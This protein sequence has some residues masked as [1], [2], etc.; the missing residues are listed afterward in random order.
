ME[1]SREKL[2][3]IRRLMALAAVL[4]L[5]VIYS[6]RLL[7]GI[8]FLYNIVKPFVYG[9]AIAFVL[10]ILMRAFEERLLKGWRGRLARRCKRPM[11]IILSIVTVSLLVSLVVGT[12]A[13]QVTSTAAE[14]GRKIPGFTE[15][16]IAWM[17]DMAEKYPA[18]AEQA[19][20]L[21]KLE[22]NWDSIADK[23]IDFLKNGA[24]DMLTSTVNVAG[25]IISG[26]VNTVIAF[27]FALYILAQKERLSNQGKRI[28]SAFFP[29]KAAGKLL[30]VFALLY[31]NFSSF[32]TGQCL[33]AV[34]L[35]AMFVISMS[36][37]QMPYALMVGVLIAFTALIPIVGAFIGCGVGAFLIL[38]DNPLQ[39]MWFVILFLVLQQI[40]GNLIY[41]K[42]VGSSVG[43]PSIWVLMAVSVG[44]SLFGIAGMLM[45]IPLMST[46][47]ALLR[48]SVNGRNAEKGYFIAEAPSRNDLEEENNGSRRNRGRNNRNRNNRNQNDSSRNH[49]EQKTNSGKSRT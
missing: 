49:G 5:A 26:A 8:A 10:N 41:P 32:I 27:I 12:V 34:I 21:E 23:V 36:L 19:A 28:I 4:V 31:K 45:F 46:G 39:A 37:F 2:R 48:E 29:E 24:A 13:P 7:F 33:E 15:K 14:I 25:G 6:E 30:E 22:I 44:G 16:A 3:Q 47:Y 11:C 20:K 1:F 40:E 17:N 18:L 35:G 38:I 9:G 42:V 43:L